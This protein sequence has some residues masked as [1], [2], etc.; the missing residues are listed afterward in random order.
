MFICFLDDDFVKTELAIRGYT[1]FC[2]SLKV[3][4][5]GLIIKFK[6]MSGLAQVVDLVNKSVAVN[7]TSS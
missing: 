3:A 4:F 6:I 7:C 1:I 5:C 2:F